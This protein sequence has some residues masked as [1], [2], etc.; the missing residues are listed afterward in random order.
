MPEVRRNTERYTARLLP[1]AKARQ[2]SWS[3]DPPGWE[4]ELW[5]D[6]NPRTS[7][8]LEASLPPDRPEP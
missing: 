7:L 4:M 1:S 8:P 6:S 5:W 2:Y 3:A